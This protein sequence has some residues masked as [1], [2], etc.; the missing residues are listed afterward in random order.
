[1]ILGPSLR[2]WDPGEDRPCGHSGSFAVEGDQIVCQSRC[3]LYIGCQW[4]SVQVS[5]WMEKGGDECMG[6]WMDGWMDGRTDGRMDGWKDRPN[7]LYWSKPLTPTMPL[8]PRLPSV[9]E[10]P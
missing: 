10:K 9:G 5:E 8:L 2:R 3:T 7:I 4:M 6:G 1:M